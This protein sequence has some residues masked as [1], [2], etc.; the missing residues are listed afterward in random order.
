M[1]KTNHT[2]KHTEA[3]G[4]KSLP[5]IG[6]QVHI[7]ELTVDGVK[8]RADTLA[9]LYVLGEM[10]GGAD[11]NFVVKELVDVY[12]QVDPDFAAKGEDIKKLT[13]TIGQLKRVSATDRRADL[14][15]SGPKKEEETKTLEMP[16][17][18]KAPASEAELAVAVGG[19]HS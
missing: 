15:A 12:A 19:G 13:E 17:R 4:G 6:S 1:A 16:R 7:P 18:A 10:A 3:K 9:S 14:L 8:W 2:Q 5:R 11:L